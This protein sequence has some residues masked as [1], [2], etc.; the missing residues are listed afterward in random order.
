VLSGIDMAL[1]NNVLDGI[2]ELHIV[3]EIV[4]V[5]MREFPKIETI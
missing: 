4:M 3:I 5:A 1:T 2:G